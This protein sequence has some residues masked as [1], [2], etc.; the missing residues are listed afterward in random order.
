M[1]RTLEQKIADAEARLAR[2]K[3]RV[4]K[5]D[6]R[7]KIVVGAVVVHEALSAP[8]KARSL[9]DLLERE[10]TREV[11]QTALRPLLAKLREVGARTVADAESAA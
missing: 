2:L 3:E 9:L 8:E 7:Q 5:V 1:S 4:R 11:D 10:V 6:T